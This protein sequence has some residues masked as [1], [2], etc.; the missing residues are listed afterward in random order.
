MYVIFLRQEFEE[1]MFFEVEK[2]NSENIL[3]DW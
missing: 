1:C 2:T 3:S